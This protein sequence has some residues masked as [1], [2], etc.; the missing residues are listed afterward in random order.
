MLGPSGVTHVLPT[1]VKFSMT[2]HQIF[3]LK[4]SQITTNLPT[5]R[6]KLVMTIKI[7]TE[8]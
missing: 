1:A 8:I 7:M 5:F 3:R 2:D 4:V 6:S